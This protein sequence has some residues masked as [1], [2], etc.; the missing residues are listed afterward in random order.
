MGVCTGG[1]QT[2]NARGTGF[3]ACSGEVLLQPETCLDAVDD[4]CNGAANEGGIGCACI[5]G[6]VA[7]CYPGPAGT[8]GVGRCKAGSQVC[9]GQGTALSACVGVVLPQLD[10]CVTPADEDCDGAA[11]P[12]SG[13][14]I[15][16]SGWGGPLG[17]EG[18]SLAVDAAN[19][20]FF[21]G[22]A[23]GPVDFGCGPVAVAA[24]N[25]AALLMKRSPAGACLW[26]RSFGH[27][28]QIVGV[29]ADA[30]GDVVA[31][32]IHGIDIDIDLGNGH[33]TSVG[34][35][36]GF[37][38]KLDPGG[39]PLWSKTF[40]DAAA[41]TADSVAVDSAG[42]VIAYGYFNGTIDLGGGPLESAGSSD[43]YVV[44]YSPTG[45]HL[46]SKRFGDVTTQLAKGLAVDPSG[47]IVITG[48][49]NGT[50]SFGGA[51]V[52]TAG[53]GDSFVAKLSPGGA[54]LWSKAF[55][56]A[57]NQ[58]GSGVATDAAGDV[59]LSGYFLG[60]MNF[61]APTVP[62]TTAG[63]ADCYIAKLDPTGAPLWSLHAGAINN[64][65]FVAVAVDPFGNIGTVGVLNG[66]SS[67]GGPVL[68]SAG[69][70]DIMVAKY[71]PSGA[72]LWSRSFGDPASQGVK[73]LVF[74]N[75]GDLLFIGLIFGPTDFGGGPVIGVGGEDMFLTKLGQ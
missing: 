71:S 35:N 23:N 39:A 11:A 63:G 51:A 45:V 50:V 43:L 21:G 30:V 25:D 41:Q 74:D 6:S 14:H 13:A 7:T 62:M 5:P 15:W 69:G 44:K 53:N 31:T 4:D 52:A 18:N 28:S 3:G 46:W 36:D 10:N 32:G 20:I 27:N 19:N 58:V 37:V 56:D 34:G 33:V 65:S 38:V 24:G 57:T 73:G 54:H 2:C 60:T 8:A 61:G 16:S 67:F 75:V 29:A 1:Q 9:N 26:N 40:G 55:G 59:I 48:T 66:A 42:D 72:H 22:Y 70:N 17:D 47:N 64:Q 12:C 49:L 68:T